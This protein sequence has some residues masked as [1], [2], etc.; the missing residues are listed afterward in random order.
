V[1]RSRLAL[2]L[3]VSSGFL[4][5]ACGT[6][7]PS[8]DTTQPPAAEA[9]DLERLPQAA[10]PSGEPPGSTARDPEAFLRAVFDDAEA[11]WRQ[12]FGAAGLDYRPS[13]L[14]IFREAVETACGKQPAQAGPFYCPVDGGV[15]LNPRFFAALSARTGVRLGR[16][17][18]AYVIAH[19]LGHHV[20]TQLGLTSRKAAAD[21][22]DPAGANARSVRFELQADCLA[23]V[24][25][26][27]AYRRSEVTGADIDDALRAASVVGNDFQQFN[28]TGTI[29]PEDW[30]HGSSAQ[31][32]HWLTVGFEQG[33]P[34]ACEPTA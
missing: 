22:G 26:H 29:R 6:S 2:A 13:S 15:Y 24:W 10:V 4:P 27:S 20:Q 3:V 21:K 30:T 33:R 5:A 16:F 32:R 7:D 11:F 17:A 34:A 8:P 14:T 1:S 12:E 28:S 31:R 25:M 18:Q 9:S 23:G 19:E